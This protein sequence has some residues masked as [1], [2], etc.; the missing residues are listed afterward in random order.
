MIIQ[1]QKAEA[2]LGGNLSAPAFPMGSIPTT[3]CFF[4]LLHV[5]SLPW[6]IWPRAHLGPGSV[7]AGPWALDLKYDGPTAHGLLA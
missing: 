5:R 2:V 7:W 3:L 4:Q 6:P 1:P